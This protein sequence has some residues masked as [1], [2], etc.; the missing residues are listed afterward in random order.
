[1]LIN[2]KRCL[3][4]VLA[5]CLFSYP[6][7]QLANVTAE[8][9]RKA[10]L[11][12]FK[13]QF[14]FNFSGDYNKELLGMSVSLYSKDVID[15]ETGKKKLLAT[16]KANYNF[17]FVGA[18][19]PQKAFPSRMKAV[20]LLEDLVVAGHRIPPVD[21]IILIRENLKKM[22]KS[23]KSLLKL[24]DGVLELHPES[25]FL[26][27]YVSLLSTV[28]KNVKKRPSAFPNKNDIFPELIKLLSRL[29]ISPQ[30]EP[31]IDGKFLGP[32]GKPVASENDAARIGSIDGILNMLP[33]VIKKQILLVK[34][35]N[36]F[37]KEEYPGKKIFLITFINNRIK[38]IKEVAFRPFEYDANY[39]NEWKQKDSS[40]K[41]LPPY[42]ALLLY[43][44]IFKRFL[45]DYNKAFQYFRNNKNTILETMVPDEARRAQIESDWK[46][47]MIAGKAASVASQ[48]FNKNKNAA[49]WDAFLEA[50]AKFLKAKYALAP[51]IIEKV[52]FPRVIDKNGTLLKAETLQSFLARELIPVIKR[53]PGFNTKVKPFLDTLL[54]SVEPT[55]SI[56]M[57]MLLGDAEIPS[58]P[59]PVES[60]DSEEFVAVFEW[61]EFEDM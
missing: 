35:P 38:D 29:V 33:D 4:L 48:N 12:K 43:T 11:E 7:A 32:N 46:K 9:N 30:M 52:S 17:G 59:P 37:D 19:D 49:N 18:G 16:L 36:L 5:F 26:L 14:K 25:I 28:A 61:D 42:R 44:A 27:K 34:V 2:K 41:L 24:V 23:G 31:G 40:K 8:E 47:Y 6:V 39:T 56:T 21:G 20:L 13:S 57:D 3:S 50:K 53:T 55:G 54:L 60:N 1:M 51:F 45:A 58:P 22:G 15:P 10:E